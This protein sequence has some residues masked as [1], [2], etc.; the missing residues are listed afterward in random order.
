M[1][2]KRSRNR[3]AAISLFNF[4]YAHPP[5]AVAQNYALN[6]AIGDNE[7]GFKGN[8]DDH[9]RMEAWEFLL[10]GG[11]LYNNLD[12]SFTAGKRTELS[13]QK[14]HSGRR[15]RRV[16][17]AIE[18]PPRVHQWVRVFENAAVPEIVKAGVPKDQ[19]V[20]VLAE[21]GRQY[22][23]YVTG[24]G[25]VELTLDL[26]GG[27]YLCEWMSPLTG[28]VEAGQTINHSGGPAVVG[29]PNFAEDVALR[30]RRK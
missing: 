16:P 29:S 9:Y 1:A 27:S 19:R 8:A 18:H 2:R 6:K 21:A 17:P 5:D 26:P 7:T 13:G 23:L 28:K 25:R 15:R 20:Q 24:G 10:A 12:Y 22:S 14:S 30:I 11:A 3:I 4:H